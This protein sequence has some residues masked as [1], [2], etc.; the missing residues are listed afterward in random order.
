MFK[1]KLLWHY[2]AWSYK[3]NKLWKELLLLLI[4]S[5]L[6][7]EWVPY[8]RIYTQAGI[9]LRDC[10]EIRLMAR[11]SRITII[12]DTGSVWFHDMLRHTSLA[13]RHISKGCCLV[14]WKVVAATDGPSVKSR[15]SL[16]IGFPRHCHTPLQ[17]GVAYWGQEANSLIYS[18]QVGK[19][20]CCG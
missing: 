8:D 12:Y 10:K 5:W 13:A 20:S 2:L 1:F 4:T 7:S 14:K 19:R 18:L 9:G 6:A 15:R 11:A 17:I 16:G 3:V